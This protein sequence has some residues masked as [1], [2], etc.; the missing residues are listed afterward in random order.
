MNDKIE[1]YIDMDLIPSEYVPTEG[2]F[3]YIIDKIADRLFSS[4]L[5]VLPSVGP[6]FSIF[7][8]VKRNPD[9]NELLEVD[10]VAHFEKVLNSPD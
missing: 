3:T 8:D 4:T 5:K 2:Q 9:G 10:L 1:K 6:F 7:F